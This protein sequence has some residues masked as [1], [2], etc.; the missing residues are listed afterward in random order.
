MFRT[1]PPHKLS[2]MVSAAWQGRGV[3]ELKQW[4]TA[5]PEEAAHVAGRDRRFRVL[6]ENWRRSEEATHA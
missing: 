1:I 5:H 4:A 2:R 6:I 3:V